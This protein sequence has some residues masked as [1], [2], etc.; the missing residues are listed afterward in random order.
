MCSAYIAPPCCL[1]QFNNWGFFVCIFIY[2]TIAYHRLLLS[3]CA[4]VTECMYVYHQVYIQRLMVKLVQEQQSRA[5]TEEKLE[6]VLV[7]N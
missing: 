6:D 2:L 4:H 7:R 1:L 3:T 5:R